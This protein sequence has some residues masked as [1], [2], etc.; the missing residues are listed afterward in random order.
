[1]NTN[2]MTLCELADKWEERADEYDKELV[3]CQDEN[4]KMLGHYYDGL[5]DGIYRCIDELRAVL[6][7]QDE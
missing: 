6:E 1:M 3:K 5:S 2:P 4:K 7:E